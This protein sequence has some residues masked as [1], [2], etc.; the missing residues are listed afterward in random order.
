VTLDSVSYNRDSLSA[1][2]WYSS[3]PFTQEMHK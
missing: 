3:C 2:C 1:S